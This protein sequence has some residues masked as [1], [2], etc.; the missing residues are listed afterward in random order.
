MYKS[1]QTVLLSVC[2]SVCLSVLFYSQL[3]HVCLSVCHV[4]CIYEIFS[5]NCVTLDDTLVTRKIRVRGVWVGIFILPFAF[6]KN[7]SDVN[8]LLNKIAIH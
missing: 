4:C 7:Y 3:Y 8:N 1:K 6:E 5:T 2:L